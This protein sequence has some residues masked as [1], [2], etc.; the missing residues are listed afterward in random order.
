[1]ARETLRAPHFRASGP[2]ALPRPV[3]PKPGEQ[4]RRPSY[5]S[6]QEGGRGKSWVRTSQEAGLPSDFLLRAL[7]PAAGRRT[8]TRQHS[9][10]GSLRCGRPRDRLLCCPPPRSGGEAEERLWGTQRGGAAARDSS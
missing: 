2:Q 7:L 9:R 6:A 1:M 10:Q 4:I 3:C 8:P 5:T